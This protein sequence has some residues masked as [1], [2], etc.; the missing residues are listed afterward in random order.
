MCLPASVHTVLASI[1]VG[2]EQVRTAGCTSARRTRTEHP[3]RPRGARRTRARIGG[4]C[5]AALLS[6]S[7]QAAAQPAPGPAPPPP[8][9]S[10]A[11]PPPPPPP[12]ERNWP[13][14]PGKP[15]KKVHLFVSAGIGSC[16]R[17]DAKVGAAGMCGDVVPLGLDVPLRMPFH[18]SVEGA[19]GAM[20][21]VLS[22][23][24]LG[25]LRSGG[26][27][28]MAL[29]PL[30]GYDVTRLFFVR[31]G[32]Q[33]RVAWSLGNAAPGVMGLIDLGTRIFSRVEIGPRGFLGVDD[34]ISVDSRGAH[35][36]FAFAFGATL[37]ARVFLR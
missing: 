7:S 17:H 4:L 25:V 35:H 12:E 15:N 18:F 36:G 22:G 33:L 5:G 23:D 2:Y 6:L 16:T 8:A 21:Q 34:V 28:Y 13:D 14:E 19:F 37:L 1:D 31:A 32:P 27:A 20:S 9:G 24:N 30:F 29:R 3:A 11:P 10:Y 26:G